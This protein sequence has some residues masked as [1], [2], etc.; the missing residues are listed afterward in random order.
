MSS[1]RHCSAG[2]R[3][4]GGS[5]ADAARGGSRPAAGRAGPRRR[6]AHP[7]GRLGGD[8]PG[9][10]GGHRS[11]RR[12]GGNRGADRLPGAI[13]SGQGH[14]AGR[15]PAGTASDRREPASGRVPPRARV[16]PLWQRR[17]QG[18]F[19]P[20]R[21]VPWAAPELAD[22]GTVHVGGTRA[23]TAAAERLVAAGRH[24]GRPYVLVSQPSRFDPGRAP[25]GR[26]VLWTYCHVPAV[27]TVDM[28]EAV[29]AQLERFAPGFRTWSWAAA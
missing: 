4:R 15:R 3:P 8:R 10:G 19:H 22:A 13:A 2:G 27:S 28:G 5:P 7:G 25:A 12:C 1:H 26:Q 18:R 6:L 9:H 20:V 29:T 16:V 11:P 17:L 21:P 23:E 14:V 24:P